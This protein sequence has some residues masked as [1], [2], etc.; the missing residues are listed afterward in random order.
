MIKGQSM[1]VKLSVVS[2]IVTSVF[3][4]ILIIQLQRQV[5][6]HDETHKKWL[7]WDR[8]FTNI[9]IEYPTLNP[10]GPHCDTDHAKNESQ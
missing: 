4:I 5:T 6:F 9:K 8:L 10:L 2:G 3:D 1:N 7:V